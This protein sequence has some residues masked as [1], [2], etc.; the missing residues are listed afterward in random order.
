MKL[1]L[2]N[3]TFQSNH[4]KILQRYIN[5]KSHAHLLGVDYDFYSSL[6]NTYT[7]N[8]TDTVSSQLSNNKKFQTIVLTDLLETSDDIYSL[9]QQTKQVL[10]NDGKLVV[11]TVNY[12]YVFVIKFLEFLK[13]KNKSP[14]LSHINKR[15]IIN[16]A[17]TSGFEF[18]HS[19]TKQIIPF[20]GFGIIAFINK[21]LEMVLSKFNLGIIQYIIFKNIPDKPFL[22]KRT[23]IVPAK[24]EEGNIEILFKELSKLNL[25]EIIFSVGKS[26]DNT[27]QVI[28]ECKNKYNDLN[29]VVHEQS[30]DGKANSIW[31]AFDFVTGEVVA[32]LDSDLSVEPMELENFYTI[33]DNNYADFVNG[34]RLI[35]P[36]EKESMRTINF[37]GNRIFQFIV[38]FIIGIRLSDSLCGTKV[39]KKE[40]IDSI[41]WWQKEFSLLDPFCDFDLIFTAAITGEK[42]VEYPIHYKSRIYGST[43]I[44]RFKDGFKLIIYLIKSFVIFNTSKK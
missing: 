12:K 7:L 44:S 27:L 23:L 32:I 3:K 18:I 17:Q 22:N 13:L 9:F 41:Y 28:N 38:S 19:H 37:I 30:Q 34:S 21:F 39:F 10:T 31:E 16:L 2:S 42:I 8:K 26:K 29:I 20:H 40:F 33:I 14:K 15:H 35:Y 36:M 43:Q 4:L 5:N 1:R 24:N 11:T 6:Q 25:H